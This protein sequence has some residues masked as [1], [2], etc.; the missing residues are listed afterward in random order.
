[1]VGWTNA[2]GSRSHFGA[3]LLGYYAEDG[4]LHYAGRAGTGFNERELA[5]LAGVLKPLETPR[6]PLDK[7]PPRENRFGSPLELSRVHWVRPEVVVEVT[8]LTWT[9]GG[10]RAVSYQGQREEK[11][12]RQVIRADF[13]LIL[14]RRGSRASTGDARMGPLR[15]A[16]NHPTATRPMQRCRGRPH[17][18]AA[19]SSLAIRVTTRT[20][21]RSVDRGRATAETDQ[22]GSSDEM[23][24]SRG[25]PCWSGSARGCEHLSGYLG[26]YL[27]SGTR[28]LVSIPWQVPKC[29][30][31]PRSQRS[32]IRKSPPSAPTLSGRRHLPPT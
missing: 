9:E 19:R 12:V 3:L 4:R 26:R 30:A 25:P 15:L 24:A 13:R 11:P 17:A 8:Y 5:R 6:M 31:S 7:R 28:L 2:G 32:P 10:L 29:R 18:C 27:Q 14:D 1:M 16:P 22:I 23:V 21:S 20:S